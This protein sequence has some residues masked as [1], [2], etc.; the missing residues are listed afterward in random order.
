MPMRI[1]SL[2]AEA[3]LTIAREEE[4]TSITKSSEVTTSPS[5]DDL[6]PRNMHDSYTEFVLPIASNPNLLEEYVNASGGIRTGK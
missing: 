3:R 2:W 6:P 4:R 5:S 1:P